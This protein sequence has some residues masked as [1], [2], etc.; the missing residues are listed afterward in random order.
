MPKST[1]ACKRVAPVPEIGP[2]PHSRQYRALFRIKLG[3]VRST[4]EIPTSLSLFPLSRVSRGYPEMHLPSP[5]RPIG[6]PSRP[7][8]SAPG[9]RLRSDRN[10]TC[11][12]DAES[13]STSASGPDWIPIAAI[14]GGGGHAI[15]SFATLFCSFTNFTSRRG[16][17]A[18][19]RNP[20]EIF[21]P[22]FVCAASFREAAEI[23]R[24]IFGVFR[25]ESFPGLR[26][27][28]GLQGVRFSALR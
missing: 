20:C 17:S 14:P 16:F 22:C 27:V 18:K 2:L 11:A 7:V 28:I 21:I 3:R 12:H 25:K 23:E 13:G 9:T 8:N 19:R 4:S 6:Q 1:P 24:W 26:K 5:A 15:H 10:A